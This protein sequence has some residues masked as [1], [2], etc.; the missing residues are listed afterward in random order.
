MCG[1][2][3]R[4]GDPTFQPKRWVWDFSLFQLFDDLKNVFFFFLFVLYCFLLSDVF[5][6]LLSF[7]SNFSS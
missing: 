5:F 6:F 1:W 2:G 7:S 4:G 3:G